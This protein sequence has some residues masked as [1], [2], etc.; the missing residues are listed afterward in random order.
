MHRVAALLLALLAPGVGGGVEVRDDLGRVLAL[1]EPARRIVTLAPHAT[2]LV[3]AAGA[4]ARLVAIAAGNEPPPGLAALP[5]IGGPGA[6]DREAL[7]ALEPDLVVAW[8]SGNRAADLEWVESAGIALYR[9]EPA[10]LADVAAAIRAIAALAGTG[11]AGARA[12]QG[13]EAAL[14][15]PCR[16]LPLRPAYVQVWDRPAMSVGGR[17]WI[18]AVLRAA[19]FRNLFAGVDRGIFRIAPE[20]WFAARP[21]FEVSLLRRFDG[22]ADDRLAELLARPGP[23]LATAVQLLCQRRLELEGHWKRDA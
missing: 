16:N 2:E 15:T 4:A 8:Q 17:H 11:D 13:F 22:S 20:A 21:A 5:R 18:N 12:A 1:A 14:A 19:G 9:S 10:R 3:A 6:L 7:L 23:R